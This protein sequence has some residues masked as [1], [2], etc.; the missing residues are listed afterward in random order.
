MKE[1][2]ALHKGLEDIL[3]GYWMAYEQ[4]DIDKIKKFLPKDGNILFIGT[5]KH[6][7]YDNID[8]YI[9]GTERDFAQSEKVEVALKNFYAHAAGKVA[10]TAID[11]EAKV[12]IKGKVYPMFARF[13]A[14]L[15][16][17][18]G[19]WLFRQVHLSFPS[20][21]QQ[22]GESFPVQ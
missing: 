14:V 15:E 5:G 10:W 21:D 17:I 8:D 19:S 16:R 3:E 13:T 20:A 22:E 12:T 1:E 11:L 18:D 6:E 2:Y 4:R 9:K 7:R